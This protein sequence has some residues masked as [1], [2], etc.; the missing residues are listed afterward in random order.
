VQNVKDWEYSSFHKFVKD[1][2]YH[3]NWGSSKDIEKIK[4]MNIE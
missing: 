2:F 3:E 4:D 1:N